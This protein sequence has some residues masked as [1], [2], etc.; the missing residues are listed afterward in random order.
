MRA[1]C[2]EVPIDIGLYHIT[3]IKIGVGVLAFPQDRRRCLIVQGQGQG[4]AAKKERNRPYFSMEIVQ[5]LYDQ[6]DSVG[7]RDVHLSDGWRLNTRRV[8][9]PPVP[10]RGQA[11]RDEIR[12]RRAILPS[13]LHKD[14]RLRHGLRVVG[15]PRLRAL[16]EA[17]VGSTRRRRVQL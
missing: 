6:N 2:T 17:P 14:P 4:A 8:S 10:L 7:L 9:V 15:S 3:T 13:N 16:P 11:R 5:A 12:H 1:S